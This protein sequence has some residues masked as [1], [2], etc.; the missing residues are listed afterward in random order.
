MDEE[1][2]VSYSAENAIYSNIYLSK[3]TLA[4]PMYVSIHIMSVVA[5]QSLRPVTPMLVV[6]SSSPTCT[7]VFLIKSK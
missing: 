2:N 3:S 7:M 1:L 6:S 4:N 5:A